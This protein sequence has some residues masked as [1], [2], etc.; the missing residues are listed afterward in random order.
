MIAQELELLDECHA[1]FLF[2]E[3]FFLDFMGKSLSTTEDQDSLILC[4]SLRGRHSLPGSKL[5]HH[6]D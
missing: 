2:F 6:L 5:S 1:E 3:T 4:C